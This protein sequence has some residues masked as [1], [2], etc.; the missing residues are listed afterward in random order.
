[1]SRSPLS[2]FNRRSIEELISEGVEMIYH[3]SLIKKQYWGFW[4]YNEYMVQINPNL[5]NYLKEGFEDVVIVHE[6]LH[7][8]ED[9]I[10]D[11][12]NDFRETQIDWWAYFHLRRDQ[13]IGKYIRSFFSEQ[14]F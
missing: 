2:G 14:G 11:T 12:E 1:M 3:P 5:I 13:H 6:W 7:A 10:L 9:I 8:Y 4:N